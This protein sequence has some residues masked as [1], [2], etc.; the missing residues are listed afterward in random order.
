M[1]TLENELCFPLINN[2]CKK[3]V[4]SNPDAALVFTVLTTI[5]LVTV[6]L[7]LLVIISISHYR[8]LHTCTNLLLLSLAV[9]DLLVGVLEMPM[10]ILLYYGCFFLGDFVCSMYGFVSF[11][12]ISVSVGNMVMI[13]IDRYVAICDPMFYHTKVTYRRVEVCVISCWLFSAIHAIWMSREFLQHPDMYNS[14]YGECVILVNEIEAAFDLVVTFI[15]PISVI[16]VLY[17]R[18]FVVAVTQ[19]RVLRS[20]VTSVSV[21]HSGAKKSELKAA[22]TLG[23]VIVMFIICSCPYY[24][25]TLLFDYG[26]TNS[27][28]ALELWLIYF[29]SCINPIIYA[30]CYPWFWR[31]IK[32]IVTLQILKPGS[33]EMNIL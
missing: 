13:S 25:F 22:R 24:V 21:K 4:H 16:T 1:E 30:F 15:A 5:T 2:S 11:L 20:Q 31:A 28:G 12:V 17:M 9:S 6:L 10:E 19:A 18:V 27:S 3:I 29:N 26:L 7:N 32:N 14:C 23:V 8:Q 33:S